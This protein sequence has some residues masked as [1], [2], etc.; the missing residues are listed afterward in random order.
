[1]AECRGGMQPIALT[2]KHEGFG[3]VGEL[4]LVHCCQGCDKLS[5]NRIAADDSELEIMQVYRRSLRLE[6]KVYA[7][8][9]AAGIEVLTLEDEPEVRR[10][11]FGVQ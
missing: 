7:R 5:I 11:L 2:Y 9:M 6:Q 1:M 8:C 10:Q 4:M 3:R